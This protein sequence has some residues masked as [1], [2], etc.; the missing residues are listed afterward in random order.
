MAMTSVSRRGL[1]R[2]ASGWA[3]AL[4][5]WSG[6]AAC[7]RNGSPSVAPERRPEPSSC[8]RIRR[9]GRT[10]E[11][12]QA[13]SVIR[14]FELFVPSGYDGTTA[15]PLVLDLHGSTVTAATE[16]TM[17]RMTETADREGFVVVAPEA[18]DQL[19]NIPG[20]PTVTGDTLPA[21][22]PSDIVFLDELISH[23]ASVVC[24]DRSRVF[25][26]GFSGGGR[27][28]S[29]AGCALSDRLAAIA[30]VAGLRHPPGCTLRR[31][32]P[33]ISFHGTAD[34]LN[35][36]EGGAGARWDYGVEE[37]ARRWAVT[38]GCKPEPHREVVSPSVERRSFLECRDGAEVQLYVVAGGGHTWPGGGPVP[39][40]F[41]NRLGP[42]NSEVNATDLIWEFFRT[43]RR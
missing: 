31:P 16:L 36:F 11:T 37:A 43:L 19:W 14:R 32:L 38:N 17:T 21:T 10:T 40:E 22:A 2:W 18:I 4:L 29:Q 9:P 33:V 30:P 12:M 35:P 23:V 8:E 39:P 3:A 28:L 5:V 27:L 6:L 25:A 15:L 26:T 42:T 41:V 1:S 13:A 7:N 34:P 20:V 24:I